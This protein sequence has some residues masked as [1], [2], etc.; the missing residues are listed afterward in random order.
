MIRD[1]VHE[2]CPRYTPN[3]KVIY[4]GDA[5]KKLQV[6][7]E[8]ALK[9]L[10]IHL[11]KHGKMPDIVVHYPAKGWLVLLEAVTSHGPIGIKRHNELKDLFKDSLLPLVFV[12]AFPSR[13]IMMR[14]LREIAW[15]TDVWVS[16]T[17]DHL[18]H[19]NGERFLGPYE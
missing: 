19:F 10:G 5:G 7:D 2:F 9:A 6:Y 13:K 11:S 15:E 1:I 16:E 17:P 8:F 4:L 18:I 14:Y 12:T 3:G